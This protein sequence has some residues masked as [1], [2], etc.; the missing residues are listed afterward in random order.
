MC[1]HLG[2]QTSL[3]GRILNG[4]YELLR[5]LG[6]GGFGSVWEARDRRVNLRVAVKIL[7]P[8]LAS[9][10]AYV[11]R[12]HREV[13]VAR[14]LTSPHIV[15]VHGSGEYDGLHYVVM[16]FVQGQ[17]LADLLA[18]VGR[19]RPEDAFRI[20]AQVA[21]ALEV[22]H[23]SGVVHR[24]VKPANI[25]VSGDRV[26]LGDFGIAR[27]EDIPGVTA[28]TGYLGTVSYSSP[29]QVRGAEVDSRSDI[30]SLGAVL[31]H[32]IAGHPP[33][34]GS[35][36][37]IMDG[38]LR[39]DPPPITDVPHSVAAVLERCLAKEPGDR[40]RSAAELQQALSELILPSEDAPTVGV[41]A[42]PQ[43]KMGARPGEGPPHMPTALAT[44]FGDSWHEALW[45]LGTAAAASSLLGI[46]VSVLIL[47]TSNS[48]GIVGHLPSATASTSGRAALAPS[49][50]AYGTTP[51]SQAPTVTVSLFTSASPTPAC[52]VL[53]ANC[54]A[55]VT[56]VA[57]LH[58]YLRG[59]PGLSSAVLA[60][61]ADGSTVCIRG[62]PTSL[63]GVT[64]WPVRADV[65][66]RVLEGWAAEYAPTAPDTKFLKPAGRLCE[67]PD[68]S[69]SPN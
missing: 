9:E 20:G 57:P 17:T 43:R 63:D 11:K 38:H 39:H 22:A 10:P 8:H 26:K 7:H 31:Y 27:V 15:R 28:Q 47:P 25:Y 21:R 52:D 59:N 13:M 65:A 30:Y 64:W 23:A 67:N 4:R 46:I 33:F 14:A 56:N 44:I 3:K 62:A 55:R 58:L 37:A 18:T 45:R 42:T 51:P 53:S 16:E 40:F 36:L 69:P 66:Q 6:S 35:P 48:G 68:G 24:D 34:E 54:E 49:P 12:L 32:C 60:R 50:L 5:P 61:M 2:G 1:P 19:M 41:P 29:E